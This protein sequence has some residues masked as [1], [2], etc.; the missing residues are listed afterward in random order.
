MNVALILKFEH[1]RFQVS[2]LS[3]V[4]SNPRK[5]FSTLSLK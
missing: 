4:P 5:T 1:L 3:D 2:C